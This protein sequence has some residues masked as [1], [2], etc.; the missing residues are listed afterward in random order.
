MHL[1]SIE[2]LAEINCFYI[3]IDV[4][5]GD[6]ISAGLTVGLHDPGCPFQPKLFHVSLIL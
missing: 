1:V 2:H 3:F 6:M 5:P 4:A